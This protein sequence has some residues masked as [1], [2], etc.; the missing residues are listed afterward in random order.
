MMTVECCVCA[1][2]CAATEQKIYIHER[3]APFVASAA[4]FSSYNLSSSFDFENLARPLL[5]LILFCQNLQQPVLLCKNRR[6]KVACG[7]GRSNNVA[8]R[9]VRCVCMSK[10]VGRSKQLGRW[11][12]CIRQCRCTDNKTRSKQQKTQSRVKKSHVARQSVSSTMFEV[13]KRGRRKKAEPQA[14]PQPQLP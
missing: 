12:D 6:S 10:M 11:N 2:P 9:A 8:L 14:P 3:G 13:R 5:C 7:L 1:C 4:L